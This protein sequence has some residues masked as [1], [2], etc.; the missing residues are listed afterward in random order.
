[1]I[2]LRYSGLMVVWISLYNFLVIVG[3]DIVV[4]CGSLLSIEYV[5]FYVLII[6][7]VLYKLNFWLFGICK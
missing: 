5:W 6:S 7:S 3:C 1:M 2:Y 4:N